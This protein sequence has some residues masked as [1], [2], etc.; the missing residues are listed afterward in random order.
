MHELDELID[1][2]RHQA[3]LNDSLVDTPRRLACYAIRC[4]LSHSV[5]A[6]NTFADPANL[7]KLIGSE[8]TWPADLE[9]AILE[10]VLATLKAKGTQP[11]SLRA[12]LVGKD[13]SAWGAYSD[14]IMEIFE[15]FPQAVLGAFEAKLAEL[16]GA[17]AESKGLNPTLALMSAVL[18]LDDTESKLLA[19]AEARE[20]F[21]PLGEFLRRMHG[22]LDVYYTL[23]AAAIGTSKKAIQVALRPTEPLRS[24]GLVRI[25]PRA[26]DL[27]DFLR[28]DALGERLLSEAFD[29]REELVA[30]FMEAAPEPSLAAEDFPH[31]AEELGLLATYLA[32]AREGK[33]KGA[34]ILIYG[35]PGTGKSE[36]ARLLATTC[37]L[38]AYEVKSTD[39]AGEPVPGRHRLMH[40]TWLQRFL[41]E[42]DD[43]FLIFDEVEDAFPTPGESG[44]L[45]GPKRPAGRL[46]GQSKAWMN[47]QLE[48]SGVPCIWISNSIDGVDEAYLRRFAFH[49][50]VRIPPASVRHQIASKR[51]DGLS[52]SK[53]FISGL[54]SDETLSPGQIGQAALFARLCS[55]ATEQNHERLMSRAIEA[56]QRAMGRR[57][58]NNCH[59]GKHE[60]CDFD[61]LNLDSSIPPAKLIASLARTAS[62]SV[63]L[64]GLPGTG[65]T[66]LAHHIATEL[67]KPLTLKRASD[68]LDMYVGQTEKRIAE[69]FRQAESEG[70]VLF[71]DEADSFLRDRKG[72]RASWQVSQV[73]ELLQQMEA[74]NGIFICATNL[75]DEVDAAALRRF[76]FKIQFRALDPEQRR[77]M[78]ADMVLGAKDAAVADHHATRLDQL[79]ALTPGDFATVR[80]QE[81]LLGDRYGVDEFLHLLEQECQ[82]KDGQACRSIG[83][84]N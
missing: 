78:F 67:G 80:R 37:G 62:G 38:T 14:A 57:R 3:D 45:F 9:A 55:G 77:R 61:Y 40:F 66:S 70:A 2:I 23:V 63:C 26:R 64:Y 51:L 1:E 58:K 27:E 17:D 43:T 21:R 24:F 81:Q 34:N 19:F 83:F 53:D 71:L 74:F 30:H 18:G 33:I 29:S 10:R 13:S 15:E 8:M 31:L 73:N 25:D 11:D 32:K 68:L 65:K 75:M 84:V 12:L 36:F 54:A 42:Q 7:L 16:T 52:I 72:A 35:P 47:Q 44:I 50:E 20:V 6:H 46:A 22:G 5:V 4:L 69:M 59:G 56:S 39:E 79:T 28:L 82:V 48:S 41:S 76:T 60:A 49:L